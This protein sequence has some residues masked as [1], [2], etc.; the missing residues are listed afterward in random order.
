MMG[1]TGLASP[2]GPAPVT[3]FDQHGTQE[4]SVGGPD[5]LPGASD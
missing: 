1:G 4:H 5:R 2:C 3:P